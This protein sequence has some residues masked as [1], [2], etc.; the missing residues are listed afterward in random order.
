MKKKKMIYIIT[1]IL[2][3][4]ASNLYA[5]EGG[6][7]SADSPYL[8]ATAQD[9]Q[10]IKD[11]PTA[12]YRLVENIDLTDFAWSTFDFSGTLDGDG[13]E[14]SYLT[15]PAG[16][17]GVGLFGNFDRPGV[18]RNLTLRNFD[19][20][21]GNWA[22]CLVSTSGN[23]ED[24]KSGGT[25]ENCR[26]IDC[27]ISG[28]E[29]IGIF[30][31]TTGGLTVRNC[32]AFNCN[33]TGTAN[34]GGIIGD[35]EKNA[36]WEYG[37]YDCV[38]LGSIKASGENTGGIC[39]FINTTTGLKIENCVTYGD[40][41]S[42]GRISG[43]ICG[44]T[45]WNTDK[46]TINNCSS[47]MN[48]TSDMVGGI[49]GKSFGL[50]MNNCYAT[51]VLKAKKPANPADDVWSGGLV[52]RSLN[53]SDVNDCYFS[54]TIT[55][56]DGAYAGGLYGQKNAATMSKLYYN[57]EGAA[58]PFADGADPSSFDIYGL[59]ATQMKEISNF[60][61]SDMSKWTGTDGDMTPYLATQAA[62]V[63]INTCDMSGIDGTCGTD[64][65]EITIIDESYY[66]TLDVPITI[67]NGTFKAEFPNDEVLDGERLVVIAKGKDTMWS[68]AV[69]AVVEKVTTGITKIEQ[70]KDKKQSNAIY[71]MQG[72]RI[73]RP[74][75]GLYITNGKKY[76]AR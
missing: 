23:W 74:A 33:V 9:L 44:G 75:K 76:I 42:T 24:K 71:N 26:A 50:K 7:G 69:K 59:T 52:A 67:N 2:T 30:A 73:T 10:N 47:Y 46:C 36:G 21:C 8:V 65:E 48:I 18:I 4:C 60:S 40:I 16:G 54:G 34:V 39:G 27:N 5:F 28:G 17:N 70:E 31:G 51:G 6:N 32:A 66:F 25:I 22:G 68:P 13:H 3:M 56:D 35:S 37:V 12:C 63:K 53:S 58:T 11:E 19:I 57:T 14:I 15:I 41:T 62:P 49:I 45:N 38:F 43:G 55:A 20:V 72:V 64:V 1:A 61:F 29:C